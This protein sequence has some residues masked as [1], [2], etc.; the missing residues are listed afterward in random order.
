MTQHA[1]LAYQGRR[2]QVGASVTD[3]H[4][5][6]PLMQT[7]G[8]KRTWFL[9]SVVLAVAVLVAACSSDSTKSAGTTTTV[10]GATTI[11]SGATTVPAATSPAPTTTAAPPGEPAAEGPSAWVAG[12]QEGDPEVTAEPGVCEPFYDAIAGGP[13][14]VQRCGI[15]NAQ[16]GQRMW[17]VTLGV[18]GL[19]H[20]YI[21]QQGAPNN[22][23]PVMRI[24]QAAPGV[25]D[26]IN[27]VTGNIDTGE[28]D[29]LVSGI[30]IA[31]TG[32]YLSVNVVDIRSGNP[33]SMA[34]Y[35]EIPGGIAA[36]RPNNGVELWSAVYADTD[37]ECCPSHFQQ[38]ALVA[39]GSDWFVV[40]GPSVPTGDPSIPPTQF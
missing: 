34:V 9:I 24:V 15:W 23:L 37:P 18:G 36:L 1:A 26:D 40:T 33:R 29:E 19:L 20:A 14:T 22:W 11:A 3:F 38:Y 10:I 27:I 13:Y 35:N 2:S 8:I 6:P 12:S 4:R 5:A 30:R 7:A 25:W 16:G 21:W 32:G 31:G 17:T 39:A 28:N